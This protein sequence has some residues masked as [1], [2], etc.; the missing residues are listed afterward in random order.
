MFRKMPFMLL[1]TILATAIR[2]M[3][4]GYGKMGFLEN[5]FRRKKNN[6]CRGK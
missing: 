1:A 3:G 5:I 6:K 2:D 4:G